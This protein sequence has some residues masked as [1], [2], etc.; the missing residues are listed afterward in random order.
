PG[1][2][3]AEESGEFKRPSMGAP[4]RIASTRTTRSGDAIPAQALAGSTSDSGIEGSRRQSRGNPLGLPEQAGELGAASA[5]VTAERGTLLFGD[6]TRSQ[7]GE[8]SPLT[9]GES[10][11]AIHLESGSRAV[12]GRQTRPRCGRGMGR[13]ARSGSPCRTGDPSGA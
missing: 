6:A 9:F 4:E 7:A 10:I 13:G 12:V 11:C 3:F 1:S 8:A 2:F 5:N